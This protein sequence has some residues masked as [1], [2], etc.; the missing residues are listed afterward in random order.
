MA[1]LP[2][3]YTTTNLRKRKRKRKLKI[4]KANTINHDKWLISM[5]VAPEQ[6][7]QKKTKNTTWKS[8]YSDSLKVDRSTAKYDSKGLEGIA[9][10]C[11]NRSLM[12]N[13]HKESEETKAAILE[14]ASRVMPLY[15]KGGLQ[16]LT[17]SS[18]LKHLNKTVRV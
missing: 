18:D 13:L 14:K 1:L 2:A 11:P 5:G 17:D 9:S 16:I 12:A 6:I 8:E 7:K 15:N 10:P 3:Y 4:E